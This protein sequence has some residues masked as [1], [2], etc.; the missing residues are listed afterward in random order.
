MSYEL[1]PYE[2]YFD[3]RYVGSVF[4]ENEH[5]ALRVAANALEVL[6]GE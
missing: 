4:A 1:N 5:A 3:G 6:H 2:V